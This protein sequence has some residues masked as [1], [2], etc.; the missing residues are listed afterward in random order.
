M[1]YLA[2][3]QPPKS[4][5][6]IGSGVVTI[7][8]SDGWNGGYRDSFAIPAEQNVVG[9]ELPPSVEYIGWTRTMD[10]TTFQIWI[11][12]QNQS[13]SRKERYHLVPEVVSSKELTGAVS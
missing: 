2:K 10:G 1:R 12:Y 3:I 9:F 7:E 5:R 4:K 6:M 8:I 13:G 11:D